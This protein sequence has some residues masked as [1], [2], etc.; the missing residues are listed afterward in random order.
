MEK[1]EIIQ[2]QIDE[3]R[4]SIECLE[5]KLN[6]GICGKPIILGACSVDDVVSVIEKKISVRNSEM[7]AKEEQHGN[8]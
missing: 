4:E 1:Y 3:L 7:M 2:K 8:E 6:D 5:R